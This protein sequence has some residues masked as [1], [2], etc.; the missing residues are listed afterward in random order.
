MI[1][2]A[3][4]IYAGWST[5]T[6][7]DLPEAEVI[8]NG[9]SSN[10]KKK[11]EKFTKEHLFI[12]EHENVPLPGF[13]LYKVDRKNWGS[14]D[15]TWL[16]ID[17]RGFLVRIS[18]DNLEDILYVTGIT[19]GL[20]QEKCVWARDDSK[21]TMCLVPI[22]SE[23]YTE[24]VENTEMLDNKI[25]VKEINIGD[26][27]ILQNK[28]AGRF[29]GV[30]SLYA[31]INDYAYKGEHK[32]QVFMRRQIVEIEPGKFHYQSDV[33][34]LKVIKSIETPMTRPEAV[35]YMNSCIQNNPNTFFTT[36]TSMTNTYYS[37]RGMI[38]HVS[39]HAV[40][41]LKMSFKELTL[42][43]A[44]DLHEIAFRTSDTGQLLLED[45]AGTRYL[46]RFPYST[47]GHATAPKEFE[48]TELVL[49]TLDPT[50]ILNIKEGSNPYSYYG[51]RPTPKFYKL[52]NFAKFY[53]IVKHV[54]DESYV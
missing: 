53:K 43:E 44:E 17:P 11:L 36:G 49:P 21:T 48:V 28:L 37:T 18:N 50:E 4:Q 34:A 47:K 19:E 29:L 30:Q 39:T 35:A 9:T 7:Y 1:N 15:Q 22:T 2:I 25:S 5:V 42:S 14:Q 26:E 12:K 32:P 3:K 46:V 24:A 33:K 38:K 10:E 8:P 54:K 13:T 40:P 51:H 6:R 31:P 45:K 27:V 52:D 41:K 16:I 20:I 23:I